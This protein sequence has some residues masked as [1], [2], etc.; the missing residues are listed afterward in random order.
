MKD[1][2]YLQSKFE[3][4]L[5][6]Y[7]HLKNIRDN[8]WAA[9]G[10]SKVS[11][12]VGAGFS[13]NAKKIEDSLSGMAMWDDLKKLLIQDLIHHRDIQHMNVLN[14]G[15]IYADEYGRSQLDNILK[16]AIPDNNYEP[17]E[18]HSKFL[19]L[20][21]T[22][23]Y[24]TNYDTL[25][26]RASR[27][28]Y[29]RN[30]QVIYDI[31]DI[32][33]SV[34]PRIVKLHGSFPA[35]RPFVFTANDY[36][37]YP[38]KFSPF[39]NMV[40]QS[41]MET[42]FVLIGFSG[43]DPNFLKWT[44]W[45]R[46]NLGIHMPK[47]YMLGYDQKHRQGELEAKGITLI[48][49]K[50]IYQEEENPHEQMFNDLFDF[51]S[52]K[53]REEKTSW[54]HKNFF[55]SAHMDTDN[56]FIDWKFILENCKYN[57]E[58]YPGWVIIP[59]E[60]RRN[61]AKGLQTA[62]D[63]YFKN[64]K[65]DE[66]N[67][68]DVQ[69]IL[70]ILWCMDTFY[71]PFDMEIQVKM[72]EILGIIDNEGEQ[73]DL[74]V[75][76]LLRLLKESRLDCNFDD[77][78]KYRKSIEE[79]KL[80]KENAH[81]FKHEKILFY[82]NF[83]D[84]VAVQEELDNWVLNNNEIEWSLKKAA[85]Y[86]NI[87]EW[88]KARFILEESL[89]LVRSLLAVEPD[90]YRLLS[91]E[92]IAIHNYNKI[93]DNK[94]NSQHRLKFLRKN[95]CDSVREYEQTLLTIKKIESQKQILKNP[96]FD[97][98][99]I[100]IVRNYGFNKYTNPQQDFLDSFAVT[101]IQESFSLEIKKDPRF[102]LALTNLQ[103]IYPLYS[104]IKLLNDY[105][106]KD[107]DEILSREAV[108]NLGD[109]NIELLLSLVDKAI[110]NQRNLRRNTNFYFDI[111]SRIYFVLSPDKQKS[112]DHKILQFRDLNI[113]TK[114]LFTLFKRIIFAKNSLELK[115]FCEKILITDVISQN[116]YTDESVYMHS[117]FDPVLVI[118]KFF[119][120]GDV[121]IPNLDI[122]E[123]QIQKLL[124][125]LDNN[126]DKSIREVALLRL[127]FLNLTKNLNESRNDKFIKK[128]KK[129]P[130]NRKLGYS[131]FLY[132]SVFDKII[133]S[134][135]LPSLDIKREI[136]S[137]DIPYFYREGVY[138][139]SGAIK[140]YFHKLGT[141]L[142]E[143]VKKD[144]DTAGE[145]KKLFKE[146]FE[147]FYTWWGSQ[148]SALLMNSSEDNFLNS[149]L[150]INNLAE[151]VVMYLRRVWM[152]TPENFIDEKNKE[153]SKEIY[154]DIKQKKPEISLLLIPS[155]IK[156]K[157]DIEKV[158]LS[159]LLVR[160]TNGETENIRILNVILFDYL[161]LIAKNEIVDEEP[162]LIIKEIFNMMI[163]G[164]NEIISMGI[165]TIIKIIKNY[166][167]FLEDN[168]CKFIVD[169]SNNY[170]SKL[171]NKDLTSLEEF[172]LVSNFSLMIGLLKKV[173]QICDD[174]LEE[175]KQ[176]IENHRLPEVRVHFNYFL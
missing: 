67:E 163:Y 147:K 19:R 24:T 43:D 7:P 99:T 78:D 158:E 170:L 155:L 72:T 102:R 77:F 151:T 34:Q 69:Y 143:Y 54:P 130:K 17:D 127:T 25:L 16:N 134:K 92:S 152:I 61:Y 105:G 167:D 30:Y 59:D 168:D 75:K 93:K 12:M 173:K 144:E 88:D 119:D 113:N 23:V 145:E 20:P 129:L 63:R 123:E 80:N 32:P 176:Y 70:E 29:E 76:L 172:E 116:Y 39:V 10:K 122:P 94:S 33:S 41:I 104:Q 121:T 95:F 142:V 56:Y 68:I 139:D 110:S 81:Y 22:D 98:G 159:R 46:N 165:K 57:R 21:W 101:Q 26:E 135:E 35:H 141:V 156:N 31:N 1:I 52:Y 73:N 79:T 146:W 13:R 120:Q 126:E 133:N 74:K 27:R 11:V 138:R 117:F 83:N 37:E 15:Q 108:Y 132:E 18:I 154:I 160:F 112:I 149:T 42:T 66:I 114:E 97:P 136:M 87:S 44:S 91:L 5:S 84:I 90:D 175:W 171:M 82:L 36:A 169:Y 157:I 111:L 60:I 6:L 89:Q 48:D 51:L 164:S 2:E 118:L 107:I 9:N 124:T 49:F 53:N 71:I 166:P 128:L 3:S 47:I 109:K 55:S 8:L 64:F 62:I 65:M 28:V 14:I 161:E 50:E 174:D 86:I 148:K 85:A 96:G 45:V 103:D 38:D 150:D 115:S 4:R 125:Y 153:K 40:Q 140:S 137:E 131:D 100:T 162:N 106:K 58:N